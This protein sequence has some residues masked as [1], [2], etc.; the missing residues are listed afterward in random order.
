MYTH[1][2]IRL[3]AGS[4]HIYVHSWIDT[5]AYTRKT[6]IQR[7]MYS[8]AYSADAALFGSTN[9]DVQGKSAC[10]HTL[11]SPWSP[12]IQCLDACMQGKDKQRHIQQY[13]LN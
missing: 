4:F 7:H 2:R 6:C 13:L 9:K 5:C 11:D 10:I 12:S 3:T 1:M 8:S